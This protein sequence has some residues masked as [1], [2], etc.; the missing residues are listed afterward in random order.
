[1]HLHYVFRM[2]LQTYN[3]LKR[4][5]SAMPLTFGQLVNR[6]YKIISYRYDKRNEIFCFACCIFSYGCIVTVRP[7]YLNKIY[8][9]NN[10][11]KY[12]PSIVNKGFLFMSLSK[13]D[14]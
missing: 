6:T 7:L 5:Y 8:T 12:H 13:S 14:F 9:N 2:S 11:M 3:L 1:M 10:I 4:C